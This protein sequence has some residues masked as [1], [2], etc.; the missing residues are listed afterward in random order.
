MLSFVLRAVLDSCW[1]GLISLVVALGNHV[2]WKLQ[3]ADKYTYFIQLNN[4]S[5]MSQANSSA[6]LFM[7]CRGYYSQPIVSAS[8]PIPCMGTKGGYKLQPLNER[9]LY[10][11]P[12]TSETACGYFALSIIGGCLIC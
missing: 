8:G 7:F 12:T 6:L 11:A 5:S 10:N 1:V 9:A 4:L 3:F 2:Q